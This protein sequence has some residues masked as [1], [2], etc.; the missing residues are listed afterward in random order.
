MAALSC[1]VTHKQRLRC[2]SRRREASDCTV[3]AGRKLVQSSVL[4]TG[5]WACT[6][7]GSVLLGL[8]QD[9]RLRAREYK[10]R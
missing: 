7:T 9:S 1:V 5:D 4:Y 10:A 2:R 6:A 3:G 8:F